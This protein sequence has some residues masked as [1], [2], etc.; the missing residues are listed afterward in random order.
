MV[1]ALLLG[2]SM[3]ITTHGLKKI[4]DDETRDLPPPLSRLLHLAGP[5]VSVQR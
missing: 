4:A 1:L 5:T 3:V 2:P